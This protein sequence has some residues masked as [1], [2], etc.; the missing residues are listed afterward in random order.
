MIH[1]EQNQ[2]IKDD[3]N[4]VV[5][6]PTGDYEDGAL[7]EF[8][9]VHNPDVVAGSFQAQYIKYGSLVYQFNEVKELGVAIL[10]I[11]PESTHTA[12]SF[13]RMTNELLSQMNQGSLEPASLDQVLSV[14]QTKM[15][16]QIDNPPVEMT[17]QPEAIEDQVPSVLG[18][19]AAAQQNVVTDIVDTPI[20]DTGTIDAVVGTDP[21][22]VEIVN[23]QVVNPADIS[24]QGDVSQ[25]SNL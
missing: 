20:V 10:A 7:I 4:L 19:Q 18:E 6:T 12:A 1:I 2:K 23:E 16:D 13:V 17:M 8:Y 21:Q 9:D 11:D 5:I 22:G 3:D 15:Q 24:T 25:Q 14:E